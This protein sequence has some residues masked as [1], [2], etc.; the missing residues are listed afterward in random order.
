M[1]GKVVS[2]KM[3]KTAVVEVERLIVHPM[4]K[5]RMKRTSRFLVHMEEAVKV[6]QSV[7]IVE[8]RPMSKLK[9][10]KINKVLNSVKEA[11]K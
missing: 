1:Q 9:R 6:G 3:N 11:K 7:E 5:K 10:F 4:Y 8:I 2:T